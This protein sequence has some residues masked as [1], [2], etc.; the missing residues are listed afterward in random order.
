MI[1][2]AVSHTETRPAPQVSGSA[3]VYRPSHVPRAVFRALLKGAVGG[4]G[5]SRH[6]E[7]RLVFGPAGWAI[8]RVEAGCNPAQTHPEVR[9][10]QRV[11]NAPEVCG[12]IGAGG[13]ALTTYSRPYGR[14]VVGD[15]VQAGQ[16]FVR[17]C[18]G[19]HLDGRKLRPLLCS[20][21]CWQCPYAHAPPGR[22]QGRRPSYVVNGGVN[23]PRF[24][25][26]CNCRR[27]LPGRQADRDSLHQSAQ[28]RR[29]S[30]LGLL[31]GPN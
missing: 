30:V 3:A 10:A 8:P 1:A 20:D 17:C 9:P 5:V 14:H 2:Q 12:A 26:I 7:E 18:L 23:E 15:Q 25:A 24:C 28:N 22:P 13:A 31:G 16:P 19:Y 11:G 4:L 27:R 6:V 29:W 21:P